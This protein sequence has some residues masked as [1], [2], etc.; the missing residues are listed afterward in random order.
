M[1]PLLQCPLSLFPPKYP[2]VPPVVPEGHDPA[3]TGPLRQPADE[4]VP[5]G[6]R[7]DVGVVGIPAREVQ[8]LKQLCSD[9]NVVSFLQ[10]G[11]SGR[12]PGLGRNGI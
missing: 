12:G 8:E 3:Q 9:L 4:A 5:V 11:P 1:P 2:R 6:V 10:G 7:P